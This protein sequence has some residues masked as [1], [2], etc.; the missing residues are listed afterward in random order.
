MV[1]TVIIL[2]FVMVMLVLIIYLGWNFRRASQIT[3]MDRYAV[4]E[5]VTPGSP[6]PDTQRRQDTIRNPR[7]NNTFFG[8][9]GDQALTLDEHL[10]R[11]DYTPQGHEDL[12]D[13]QADETY[14][15]YE[16][17]LER[18]PTALFERFAATHE[19][20][21]DMLEQMGMSV[22]TRNSMGH[23][24]M[25]GDWRYANGVTFNGAR[26]IWTPAG[27]RVTPGESLRE[28]FFAEFDDGLEPYDS[29]GNN[30]AKAIREF[31]LSYPEY[32]GPDVENDS[33]NGG[34]SNPNNGGPL[35]GF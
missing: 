18:S 14:S 11:R 21:S 17:F 30:L 6:G 27:Y 33:R 16:E 22:L 34:V 1:E 7:L 29:G 19:H 8:L 10:D 3:N 23:S 24:R 4:W 28:V 25:N 9:T 32:R 26:N 15:Y 13:M 2:P 5:E 12:R 31:Y 35:G 20:I